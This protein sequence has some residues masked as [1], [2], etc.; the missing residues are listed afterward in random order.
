MKL[1]IFIL[2][3][4]VLFSNYSVYNQSLTPSVIA[5]GGQNLNFNNINYSFTIGQ[6]AVPSFTNGNMLT[7]G[8]QQP[9]IIKIQQP[10]INKENINVEFFPNPVSEFLTISVTSSEII[11]ELTIQIFDVTGKTCNFKSNIF[12]SDNYTKITIPAE[13][14]NSGQ[15][16]IS[17]IVNNK[18]S[19]SLKIVKI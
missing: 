19:K 5:S 2:V 16:F 13:T 8:F 6:L 10:E 14:F 17:L 18:F 4:V 1:K 7:Q 9:E 11:D 3:L 12:E 15:Y